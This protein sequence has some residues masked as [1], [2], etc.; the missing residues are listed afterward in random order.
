MLLTFRFRVYFRSIDFFS[1]N[2]STKSLPNNV[3]PF[4]DFKLF[5][6][7]LRKSKLHDRNSGSAYRVWALVV[8]ALLSSNHIWTCVVFHEFSADPCSWLN[9]ATRICRICPYSQNSLKNISIWHLFGECYPIDCTALF[10][11][12]LLILPSLSVSFFPS[13]SLLVALILS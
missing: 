4:S 13:W 10:D 5:R 8:S 1:K 2:C 11:G 3:P 9:P 6:K 12:L 7:L